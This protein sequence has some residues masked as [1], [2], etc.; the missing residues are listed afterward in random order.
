MCVCAASCTAAAACTCSFP[1]PTEQKTHITLQVPT[2]VRPD[3]IQR[4]AHA[5]LVPWTVGPVAQ[6]RSFMLCFSADMSSR[7]AGHCRPAMQV[8]A[9]ACNHTEVATAMCVPDSQPPTPTCACNALSLPMSSC[10]STA[11][12]PHL[13]CKLARCSGHYRICHADVTCR[14][15]SALMTRVDP[16]TRHP[17]V[18]PLVPWWLHL[19]GEVLLVCL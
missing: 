3:D 8:T 7:K 1:M 18:H 16:P 14:A 15:R 11:C 9:V 6:I 19:P 2:E 10:S 17:L 5:Q 13:E 4:A 12:R